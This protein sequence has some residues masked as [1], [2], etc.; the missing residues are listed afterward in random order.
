MATNGAGVGVAFGNTD[1]TTGGSLDGHEILVF[2]GG[3]KGRTD[4]SGCSENFTEINRLS[5]GYEQV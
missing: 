5:T 1:A 4:S 3:R 2:H